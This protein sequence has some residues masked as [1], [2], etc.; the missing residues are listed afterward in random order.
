MAIAALVSY[1]WAC[2]AFGKAKSLIVPARSSRACF[3]GEWHTWP[4]DYYIPQSSKERV[5]EGYRAAFNTTKL[6]G[7][8]PS[9][10]AYNAKFG[11]FDASFAYNTLDGPPNGGKE[12]GWYFWPSVKR[13]NQTDFWR[14]APMAGET[15]PELQPI[16]F[17]DSYPTGTFEHQDFDLCVRTTHSSFMFHQDAWVKPGYSGD[18]LEKA[19]RAH[20]RMG[21]SFIIDSIAA[22]K[23]DDDSEIHIQATVKQVGVAPFYYP[24]S[25]ALQCDSLD[26]PLSLGGVDD[27]IDFG[28]IK[29]FE[30]PNVPSDP[31]CRSSIRLSLASSHAYDGRPIRFAQSNGVVSISIPDPI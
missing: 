30:F 11:L 27:L 16:V 4:E 29:V 24:L 14:F 13:A 23:T 7:R 22:F 26:Q 1:I 8:Y 25:L 9:T 5:A 18:Q 15:R 12:V 2:L 21:Y 19:L 28:S 20:T 3:R 6:Q 17:S 31:A 10:L